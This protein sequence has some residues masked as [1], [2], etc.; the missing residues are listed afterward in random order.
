MYLFITVAEVKNHRFLNFLAMIVKCLC[1]KTFQNEIK[2]QEDSLASTGGICEKLTSSTELKDFRGFPLYY[3]SSI[4]TQ[5]FRT[6]I[7][8]QKYS[9][10]HFLRYIVQE[11]WSV[12]GLLLI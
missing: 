11:K 3:V 10:N 9:I 7:Y 1:A 2:A 8:E 5:Y 4:Y 6:L 12:G